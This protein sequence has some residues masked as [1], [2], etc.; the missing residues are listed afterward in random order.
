MKIAADTE[1]RGGGGARGEGGRPGGKA[2]RG[3]HKIGDPARAKHGVV[4]HVAP[5]PHGTNPVVGVVGGEVGGIC[6]GPCAQQSRRGHGGVLSDVDARIVPLLS[7]VGG[8]KINRRAGQTSEAGEGEV[9]RVVGGA[10]TAARG[11]RGESVGPHRGGDWAHCLGGGCLDAAVEGQRPRTQSERSGVV[12]AVVVLNL[13]RGVVV[14][15]ETGGVEFDARGG[16]ECGL[17][18]EDQRVSRTYGEARVSLN[19]LKR[20][21][22]VSQ[23]PQTD[24][25]IQVSGKDAVGRVGHQQPR[26]AAGN[27]AAAGAGQTAG[28]GELSDELDVPGQI[29]VRA[30]PEA[31]RLPRLKGV[32]PAIKHQGAG[33]QDGFVGPETLRVERQRAALEFDEGLRAEVDRSIHSE[34]RTCGDLHQKGAACAELTKVERVVSTCG[35][36]PAAGE[37]EREAG[38]RDSDAPEL[39]GVQG[40]RGRQRGVA[41]K[42]AGVHGRQRVEARGRIAGVGG[43]SR[44]RDVGSKVGAQHH[45]RD[46]TVGKGQPAG[47]AQQHL[48][49]GAESR[50]SREVET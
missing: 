8:G 23:H 25:A 47:P 20:E 27:H 37:G 7:Q 21:R 39:E 11:R 5:L 28:G 40:A 38:A 44:A 10:A 16:G 26:A 13:Q 15:N 35:K 41:G 42:T 31:Q 12:E 48:V 2:G 19:T 14:Q 34:C 3:G 4:P 18:P 24:G 1:Q 9:R 33:G 30:R 29:E 46:K 43:E 22:A 36:Q 45:P 49:G 17:V 32:Q 6:N 50:N